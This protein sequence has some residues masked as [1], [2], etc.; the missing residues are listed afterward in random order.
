M[1]STALKFGDKTNLY[2]SGFGGTMIA[3]L[4]TSGIMC[5]QTWPYYASVGLIGSHLINQVKKK[6]INK[7]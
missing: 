7:L 5:N 3:G 1:K 6:N 2:L 4:I